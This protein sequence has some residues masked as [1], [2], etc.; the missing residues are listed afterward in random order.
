MMHRLSPL[1]VK[2]LPDLPVFLLL[3]SLTHKRMV[4]KFWPGKSLRRSFVQEPAE[5][6]FE[7]SRHGVW[8]LD[9]VLD[10]H[11]NQGV[12][13]VR[14]E[15]RGA[16]KQLVDD[17]TERPQIDCMVV[18][19]LLDQLRSHVEWSSLDRSEHDSVLRHRSGKTEVTKFNDAISRNQ[20]IL[21]LHISV[22]DSVR[23][24]VVKRVNQLLGDFSH[25]ILRE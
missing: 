14:V 8:I 20:N 3:V 5:E 12:D 16:N 15:W 6:T 10:N 4:Q 7:L 25:L 17:H 13:R 2:L 19:Q 23:V 1:V 24:Q 11:V 21:R 18:R 9:L 22:D